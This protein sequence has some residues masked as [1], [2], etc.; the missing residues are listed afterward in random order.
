VDQLKKIH[1][2]INSL[3]EIAK[4]IRGEVQG[5]LTLSVIPT[6][7]PYLLPLFLQEFAARFSNLSIKVKEQTTGEIIRQLKSRELDIG[8]VSIPLN[9]S[10]IV[11][12][13]L[14]DEPFVFY[15][16]GNNEKESISTENLD[17]S[18]LCLLEEGHC[19]RTQVLNLCEMHKMILKNKLN[20]EYKA[21][22]IDSLMRFV[23]V[24]KATTLLPYLSV[25]GMPQEE[26]SHILRFKTPQ[27]YRSVGLV[28]HRHFVKNKILEV[29]KKEITERVSQILPEKSLSGKILLPLAG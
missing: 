12:L 9:D 3:S 29:L 28:V 22:S 10:D 26:N 13:A 5:N 6:I 19:M 18:N 2:E 4:A 27:P 24:N 14:Y 23:K 16:A 17:L 25:I 21:G 1:T 8:I 15:D 7:A 20:F 11:E